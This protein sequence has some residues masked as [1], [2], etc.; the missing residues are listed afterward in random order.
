MSNGIQLNE[1]QLKVLMAAVEITLKDPNKLSDFLD[2]PLTFLIG[3]KT[4]LGE[5]LSDTEI[6]NTVK[7]LAQYKAE[8]Q[9]KV[10]GSS[11]DPVW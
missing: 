7:Y 5:Q 6:L 4:E 10:D 11:T 9:P 1:T 8:L 2:N 3:V